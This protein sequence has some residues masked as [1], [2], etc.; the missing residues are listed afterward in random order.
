MQ[1]LDTTI[2]NIA[3]PDLTRELG[4]STSEQL[5]VLSVYTLAFACTLL[6]AATLGGRLGRRRV[7]VGSVIA[8]VVTSMACGLAQNPLE[9]IV[10]RGAQGVSAALMSAQTLALIAALFPKSRHPLVFGVYGAVAGLA[11]MLGPVIGGV[12]VTADIAGWGWRTIFFVNLPMG[13]AACALAWRRLP[14][15]RDRPA[16]RID[17][18]GVAL[19]SVG[20]FLLLYPLAVGR[21][22]GWPPLLWVLLALAALMLIAF[23]GVEKRLLRGGGTP[24]LRLDLFTSRRFALGLVLSLLFFSVFAGFFFTV[25]ITTQFG[26]G[27]SALR[28]GLLALPFAIGG[29]L[30]SVASPQVVSRI[31]AART[32]ALGALLLGGG[33]ACLAVV[34]RPET[35]MLSVPAV[36][37][38]LVVG[39]LGTGVFVAPLQTTILAD[40]S[41]ETV[42]SASGCVPTVQ[43]IGASIGLAVVTVFFFGQVASQAETAVSSAR[44]QLTAELRD[45]PVEP[46]FREP[47]TQRFADCASAQ[48][49]SA[50][51]ERPAA[52]CQPGGGDTTGMAATIAAQAGPQLHHA[53]RTVAAHSFVGAF[54]AT[55]W[56]LAGACV[57]IAILSGTLGLRRRP[58]SGRGIRTGATQ[59]EPRATGK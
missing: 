42:G 56:V 51:P 41:P 35:A 48:L 4:A 40:T 46:I 33:L 17:L 39:G 21:E 43:Q 34:L 50:H 38:P 57:L 54:V 31:G 30:G 14:Q 8:F 12:L 49:T 19:S 16:A 11:A 24:L 18:A 59:H 15:L 23:V 26:L 1:M 7:F 2:V 3:L 9:L 29:A 25:S 36:I 13:V 53:T 52:G 45:S 58:R 47:V 20:L 44:T 22:M 5:F 32:L 55:L 37:A 10:A 27:Y 28:T 6:T